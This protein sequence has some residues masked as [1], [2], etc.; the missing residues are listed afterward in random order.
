[1][2]DPAGPIS[3]SLQPIDEDTLDVGKDDEATD[4]CLGHDQLFPAHFNLASWLLHF[5]KARTS[6]LTLAKYH[7]CVSGVNA[8]SGSSFQEVFNSLL[9]A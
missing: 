2:P 6:T 3:I 5:A 1:M 4:R 8:S 9:T 7:M